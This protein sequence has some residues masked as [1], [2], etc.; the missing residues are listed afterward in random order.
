MAVPGFRYCPMLI[1][2]MP[3]LPAKG[4]RMVFFSI[5]AQAAEGAIFA[6]I[7]FVSRRSLGIISGMTG[8]GGTFGAAFTQLLFFTSS[9]YGTG[10]GLQYM[11]IMTM[12]CTLP[13]T[14]VYFPQ[15]GSMFFPPSAGADEEKYYGSEWSEE[16][17]SKGLNAR[18]VKFAENSRSERGRRN[19]IIAKAA[20][21]PN[22]TNQ[23]V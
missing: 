20:T 9:S 10:Q 12:A 18:S 5:C 4:A 15:W 3:S 2:R 11:G 22:D 17:K 13:V 23:N 7:P 1:E 8:A 6:V 14:L 16:E 21:R 19:A